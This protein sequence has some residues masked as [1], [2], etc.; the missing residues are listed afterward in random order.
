MDV[1]EILKK[2]WKAVEDAG[3]PTQVEEVAFREAVRLLSPASA[4]PPTAA[5]QTG[6]TEARRAAAAGGRER[7]VENGATTKVSDEEL[8]EQ[9]AGHTGVEKGKLER[10][11]HMED[12]VPQ[13]AL[14]RV[15]LGSS[16]AKRA[17]AVA[18][19]VAV[20]RALTLREAEPPL[21][22]IREECERLRVYDPGNFSTQ[23]RALDGFQI[24]GAGKARRIRV[25]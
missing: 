25:L 4:A 7:K 16:N 20:A 11:V 24:K 5:R 12:G 1:S 23:M 18:Q 9:V 13:V 2:A 3:V 22:A 19:V 15:Q 10:V 6:P 8:Y 14:T 21:D 17:Q